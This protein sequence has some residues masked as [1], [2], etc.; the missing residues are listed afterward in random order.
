MIFDDLR[1]GEEIG[2]I[3]TNRPN[4]NLETYRSGQFKAIAAGAGPTFSSIAR[5]CDGTQLLPHAVTPSEV[6]T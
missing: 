5:T 4:R 2:T 3:D 6:L 1:P